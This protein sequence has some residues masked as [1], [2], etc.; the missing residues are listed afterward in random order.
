[1]YRDVFYQEKYMTFIERLKDLN[2]QQTELFNEM[3]RQ[4]EDWSLVPKDTIIMVRQSPHRDW[5]HQYFSHVNNIN[6][7]FN[8]YA[9]GR[10]SKITSSTKP[11]GYAMLAEESHD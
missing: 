10:T 1:M 4:P 8:V 9:D 2:E 5:K 7:D 3:E 6:N 11:Y